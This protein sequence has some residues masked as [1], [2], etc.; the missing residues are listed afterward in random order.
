VVVVVVVVT[1]VVLVVQ[2]G[3]DT[4]SL[5]TAVSIGHRHYNVNLTD[6]ALK[7]KPGLCHEKL[8]MSYLRHNLAGWMVQQR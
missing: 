3:S 1:V 5:C 2:M 7:V 4:E 6:T 8:L